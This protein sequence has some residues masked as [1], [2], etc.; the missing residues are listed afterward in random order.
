MSGLV[1]K[2]T[3]C[4]KI[5]KALEDAEGAWVS[6]TYFLHTLYLSQFHAR[7][8]ELQKQGHK[9][10]VSDFKDFAGFKSYRLVIQ[11][12]HET[13]FANKEGKENKSSTQETFSYPRLPLERS[14]TII[15]T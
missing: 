9:I 11:L 12:E 10:E 14:E 4:D 8:W 1:K 2:P 13:E 6:G 3:Q 5:L 15:G 7:I